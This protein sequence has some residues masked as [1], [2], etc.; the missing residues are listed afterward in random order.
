MVDYVLQAVSLWTCFFVS[1]LNL[2]ILFLDEWTSS[3]FAL[4]NCWVWQRYMYRYI[5]RLW[6]V[7]RR[8][9][10]DETPG[11]PPG[12]K[13]PA[14]LIAF[15][16]DVIDVC[17]V[18][19]KLPGWT[20]LTELPDIGACTKPLDIQTPNWEGFMNPKNISKTPQEVFGPLDEAVY[21]M[22]ID[23]IYDDLSPTSIYHQNQPFMNQYNPKIAIYLHFIFF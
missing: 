16:L 2:S 17:H 5:Y 22:F 9:E 18:S 8:F 6:S 3:K 7:P 11:T 14:G 10:G 20:L 13:G 15:Y 12:P 19:P 23:T 4:N 1:L 21:E